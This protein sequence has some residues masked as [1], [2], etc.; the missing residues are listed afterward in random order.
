MNNFTEKFGLEV[1]IQG[2][3]LQQTPLAVNVDRNSLVVGGLIFISILR[4]FII[5]IRLALI[6]LL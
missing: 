6:Y 3:G 5:L 1:K 4:A 2:G